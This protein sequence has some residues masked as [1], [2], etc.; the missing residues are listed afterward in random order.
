MGNAKS[1]QQLS[2]EEKH[3]ICKDLFMFNEIQAL[4]DEQRSLENLIFG[5]FVFMI[6]IVIGYCMGRIPTIIKTAWHQFMN[7]RRPA[8]VQKPAPEIF[9][10]KV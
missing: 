7:T 8:P 1:F 2:F 9:S 4:K 10:I 5:F 6:G 3:S